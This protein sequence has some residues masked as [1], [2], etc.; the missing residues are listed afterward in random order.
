ML[1]GTLLIHGAS[2]DL[3]LPLDVV[4][5]DGQVQS[6]ETRFTIPYVAWGMHE[7]ST[8]LLRVSDHVDVDVRMTAQPSGAAVLK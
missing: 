4:A 6:G 8:F 5:R 7:P 3:T 1:S 2:H